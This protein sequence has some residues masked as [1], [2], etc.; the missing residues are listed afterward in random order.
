MILT[1][2]EA[3]TKRCQESFGDTHVSPAGM[4]VAMPVPIASVPYSPSAGAAIA[5][6]SSP[7]MCIASGC[8]AWR[9]GKWAE[10]GEY[11]QPRGEPTH[12]Y[13]GKAGAPS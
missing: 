7:A 4:A 3:R 5:V 1:E 11:G 8:M 13:C 2:Q 10:R 12:G 9:W 6:Q